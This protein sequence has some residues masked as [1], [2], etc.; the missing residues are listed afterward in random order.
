VTGAPVRPASARAGRARIELPPAA[1]WIGLAI[2]LAAAGALLLEVSHGTSFWEDEWEFLLFRRGGDAATLLEPHNGHLSLVPVVVYKL[3][4]ATVGLDDYL[5]YRLVVIALHLAVGLLVYVY[6]ARRVGALPALLATALVLFN[7]PAWQNIIWP[8]QHAWLVSLG[9][10]LGALLCLDRRDRAGDA[11]ATVLLL[12]ALASSGLGLPLLLGTAVELL[13][14]RRRDRRRLAVVAIPAAAYLIWYMGYGESTILGRNVSEVP[15]FVADG[16]AAALS[17]ITGLSGPVIP[18]RGQVLEWGRPLAVVAAALIGWRLVAIGRIRPR[19]AMLAVTGASFWALTALSRAEIAHPYESRYLYVGGLLLVLLAV[20]LVSGVALSRVAM[21][22]AAAAVCVVVVSNAG[23]FRDGGKFLRG[24]GA[25][26]RARAGA[27]DIARP[28]VDRGFLFVNYGD[29]RY[30]AGA[31]YDAVDAYGS[32]GDTPDALLREGAGARGAADSLLVAA[33]EIA[34]R[35]AS[36]PRTG[37]DALRVDAAV[38]G[39]AQARGPCVAFAPAAVGA[40]ESALEL[41][42]PP[43]GIAVEPSPGG[44]VDAALRRFGNGFQPPLGQVRP[45]REAALRAPPDRADQSWHVRL[46]GGASFRVCAL[47]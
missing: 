47:G 22:V 38:D 1:P 40:G 19:V 7:G 16:F 10:G 6:S 13:L 26:N 11:G 12:V 32:F 17:S 44:P 24:Y 28:R 15:T 23:D 35:P 39:R 4:F 21:A 33:L 9:A 3:L 29:L 37:G 18:D 43:A 25:A 27:L 36:N 42:L 31:Y 30:P 45:G 34:L 5:P 46:T 41:T 20:E 14:G 8:F 2:L